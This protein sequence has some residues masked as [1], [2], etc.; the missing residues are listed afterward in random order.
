[1]PDRDFLAEIA[2]RIPTEVDAVTEVTAE[3]AQATVYEGVSSSGVVRAYATGALVF[4][5]VEIAH[6]RSLPTLGTDIVEAV[7]AAMEQASESLTMPGLD[8]AIAER[9]EE[10]TAEID[11]LDASLDGLMEWIDSVHSDLGLARGAVEDRQ[12]EGQSPR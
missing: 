6:L 11:R 3:E 9:V 4:S 1:M 2:A 7:N 5:H 12:D 8:E 10:F